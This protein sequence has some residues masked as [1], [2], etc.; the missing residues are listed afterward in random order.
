LAVQRNIGELQSDWE[1]FYN[2]LG[3]IDFTG[4]KVAILAQISWLSWHFS[5][6]NGH[7][8]RKISELRE[9]KQA[10]LLVCQMV[11]SLLIL[12]S[13]CDG[14]SGLVLDEDNQI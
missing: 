7:P 4:K 11:T 13:N 3:K 5:R 2:Q 9:A 1:D 12:K 10:G 14:K 6:C 8:G